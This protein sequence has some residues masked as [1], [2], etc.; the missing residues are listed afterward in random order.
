MDTKELLERAIKERNLIL[1]RLNNNYLI[2]FAGL[3]IDLN[4]KFDDKPKEYL[5]LSHTVV[6]TE[7]NY[8]KQNKETIKEIHDNI[9]SE[10]IKRNISHKQIDKLD[11][12]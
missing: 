9:K 8:D 5:I 3:N 10:L 1:N 7:F 2:S 11:K 6:H 4:S 12:I